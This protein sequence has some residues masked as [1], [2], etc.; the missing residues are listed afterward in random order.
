MNRLAVGY[1]GRF[2]AMLT[3]TKYLTVSDSL[4]I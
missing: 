3:Y 2:D 4:D 1:E